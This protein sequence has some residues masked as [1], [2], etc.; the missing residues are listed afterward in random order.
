MPSGGVPSGGA[1][2]G[3][4]ETGGN[5]TGGAGG[6]FDEC[7]SPPCTLQ[8]LIDE[9]PDGSVI[10]VGPDPVTTN[11]TVG[12]QRVTLACDT[13]GAL[14]RFRCADPNQQALIAGPG[15]DV[16]VKGCIFEG[17]AGGTGETDGSGAI[18]VQSAAR[19]V[20]RG[21]VFRG[22]QAHRGAALSSWVKG[23]DLNLD[24]TATIVFRDNVVYGNEADDAAAIY[25]RGAMTLEIV[26]N[27]FHDNVALDYAAAIWLRDQ[28]RARLTFRRNVVYGCSAARGAPLETYSGEGP[29]V[30]SS[31]VLGNTPEPQLGVGWSA[32][33][34][35]TSGPHPFVDPATGDFALRPDTAAIDAGDPEIPNDLDGTRADQGVEVG[36]LPVE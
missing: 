30:N 19:L 26:N 13:T 17:C 9:A 15:S 4:A 35:L 23:S 24:P 31:I 3:G 6:L 10:A 36:R 5:A 2:A 1:E 32:V 12:R 18:L 7:T 11:L 34:S 8:E 29:E 27:L 20:V 16:T 33:Y 25:L 22:L 21:C 14:T 28:E